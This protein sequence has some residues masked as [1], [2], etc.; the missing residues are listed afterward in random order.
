MTVVAPDPG[1][2]EA[3]TAGTEVAANPL[4]EE[5]TFPPAELTDEA[6]A[7]SE[8]VTVTVLSGT[9]AV[10]VFGEVETLA[11]GVLVAWLATAAEEVATIVEADLAETATEDP[12]PTT[13]VEAALAA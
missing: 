1:I 7:Q 8:T 3:P 9:R 10:T 2:E 12:L 11:T 5:V 4:A 6:D 13:G